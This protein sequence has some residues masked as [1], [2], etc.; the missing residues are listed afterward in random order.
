M[1]DT[2]LDTLAKALELETHICRFA[3]NPFPSA[4]GDAEIP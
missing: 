3:A 1:P 4:G 2:G